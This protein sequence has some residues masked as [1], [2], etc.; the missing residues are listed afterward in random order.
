M[1]ILLFGATSVLYAQPS[2]PGA[3]APGHKLSF[4][5]GEWQGKG[6]IMTRTGKEF[7]Q[8]TEKAECKLDCSIIVVSGQGVKVDSSSRESKIVHD[9]FGVITYD[10]K[11]GKYFIRAYK[12]EEVVESEIEFLEEK[13]IRWVLPIPS[14]GTVRFTVDFNTPGTWKETGEFS[15]DGIT[16]MK[17]LEMELKKMMQ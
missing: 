12:K 7:S 13:K 15:R 11:T 8:V 5:T 4:M 17:T 1:A 9:A 10:P 2:G 14:A 3:Q 6:W 16:W